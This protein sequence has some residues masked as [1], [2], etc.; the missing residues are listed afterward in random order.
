MNDTSLRRFKRNSVLRYG[1]EIYN[2]KLDAAKK[3][4]LTA[5][6]RV[7]RDGQLVLDGKQAPI[8]FSGQTDAE[9]VKSSGAIYL[10]NAMQTGDYILQIIV[11]DNLAKEKRRIST[12]FV[13]FEIIE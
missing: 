10:A 1:F 5:K 6:I 2:A 11:T 12:Q 3:A 9:R 13:Q 7:F 8:E 4:N